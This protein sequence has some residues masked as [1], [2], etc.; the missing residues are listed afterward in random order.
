MHK[1]FL[2]AGLALSLLAGCADTSRP[3]IERISSTVTGYSSDDAK[4]NSAVAQA[5]ASLPKALSVA[6]QGDGTFAP[7]LRLKAAFPTQQGNEVIW[8]GDIA[9]AKSGQFSGKLRNEPI[10]MTGKKLGSSVKFT[11]AAIRDWS[12]P[13]GNGKFWGN[14]TT[15]VT[16][17]DFGGQ[18]G[19][20]LRATLKAKPTP[21]NW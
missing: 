18:E 6:S 2:S 14:Y 17:G 10:W 7:T 1:L 19:A 4:M 8:I 21:A 16:A 3:G 13:A 12:L 20:A 15:R 9:Q 11:Q 5:R